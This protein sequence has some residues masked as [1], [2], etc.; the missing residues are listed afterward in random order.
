MCVCVCFRLF[1]YPILFF[2]RS[3]EFIFLSFDVIVLGF[4]SCVGLFNLIDVAESALE[5]AKALCI[6]KWGEDPAVSVQ[7]LTPRGEERKTRARPLHCMGVQSYIHFI[8]IELLKNAMKAVLDRS[9]MDSSFDAQEMGAVKV[10]LQQLPCSD[11]RITVE[12]KGTGIAAKMHEHATHFFSTTHQKAVP[13]YTYS[14]D[15]GAPFSGLGVGL[16]LSRLYAN[17]HGGSLTLSSSS[18]HSTEED[19]ATEADRA[20]EEDR[21]LTSVHVSLKADGSPLI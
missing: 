19:R 3:W 2:S 1:F 10:V 5:D 11:I 9:F 4:P 15:F 6:E 8:L 18:S 16:P 17:L 7:V 20:T 14:G 12:D 13:T 21:A